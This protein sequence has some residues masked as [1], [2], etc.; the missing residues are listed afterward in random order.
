MWTRVRLRSAVVVGH[1]AHQMFLF[2]ESF[3]ANGTSN[4]V[5][6]QMPLPMSVEGEATREDSAALSA[7]PHPFVSP[8]HRRYKVLSL[9][10]VIINFSL[11]LPRADVIPLKE[12]EM[13]FENE[14]NFICWIGLSGINCVVRSATCSCEKET[15]VKIASYSIL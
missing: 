1:V 11:Q 12:K 8:R 7:V 3:L 10:R 14:S 2:H 13:T 15:H 5:F 6:S 9:P 4:F